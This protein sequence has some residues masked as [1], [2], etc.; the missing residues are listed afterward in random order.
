MKKALKS[1][2]NHAVLALLQGIDVKVAID[3]GKKTALHFAAAYGNA[4]I[5]DYLVKC[6]CIIDAKDEDEITP[7]ML[8]VYFRHVEVMRILIDAG[9]DLCSVNSQGKSPIFYV[10]LGDDAE[11]KKMMRLA[12]D[13]KKACQKIAR[14][15]YMNVFDSVRHNNNSGT[16]AKAELLLINEILSNESRHTALHIAVEIDPKFFINVSSTLPM[17][18]YYDVDVNANNHRGETPLHMAAKHL[19]NKAVAWLLN[20][21]ADANAKDSSGQIPL[22]LAFANSYGKSYKSLINEIV[23]LLLRNGSDVCAM[24]PEGATVLE[25]SKSLNTFSASEFILRELALLEAQG[26]Q[27]NGRILWIIEANKL[28]RIYYERCKV[29]LQLAKERK[30]LG[31]TTLFDLLTKDTKTLNAYARNTDFREKF[32]SLKVNHDFPIISQSFLNKFIQHVDLMNITYRAEVVISGI[33]PFLDEPIIK[34][35]LKYL[36]ADNLRLLAQ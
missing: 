15:L 33:L 13:S 20:R 24:S 27:L 18:F 19:N 29:E 3:S 32:M 14:K 31:D 26:K 25:L 34:K 6:G 8:A 16:P 30:I 23:E 4:F 1:G 10:K 7:I 5:T 22:H 36:T 11:I 35:I 21:G 12:I 17:L 2:E 9:A 28:M